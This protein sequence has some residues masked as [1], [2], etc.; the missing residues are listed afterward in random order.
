MSDHD[1][2]QHFTRDG[3]RL[4]VHHDPGLPI[5]AD[6]S[7]DDPGEP[8]PEHHPTR[9]VHRARHHLLLGVIAMGGFVGALGRYELMQAW[10][11]TSGRLPWATLTIN[12]SGA[13]L[14]GVILTVLL[15]RAR[16]TTYLRPFLCVGILGAWTTMSTFAVESDL[17]VKE[18]HPAVAI[19]YVI[20]TVITGLALAWVGIACGRAI[21]RPRG[22][23]C[24]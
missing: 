18:G 1:R 4:W 24:S 8:S 16:P 15:S 21:V 17:L 3:K 14:L 11:T 23:R 9:G 7:P 6:L 20:A 22:V 19:A 13:F 2:K 10:P 12:T 5:D